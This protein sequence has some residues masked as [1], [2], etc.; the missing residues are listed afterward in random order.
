ML[1]LKKLLKNDNFNGI[2]IF[3]ENTKEDFQP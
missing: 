3:K 1:S 2:L